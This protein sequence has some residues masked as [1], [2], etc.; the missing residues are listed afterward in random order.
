MINNIRIE[1]I[2]AE[3]FQLQ[4]EK[5]NYEDCCKVFKHEMTEEGKV[6]DAMYQEFT[7]KCTD[8]Y[9]EMYDQRLFDLIEDNQEFLDKAQE[10]RA[11]LFKTVDKEAR[12]HLVQCEEKEAE[13]RREL[14]LLVVV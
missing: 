9:N 7:Y 10:M 5:E 11:K 13:L 12:N 3:L 4:L 2:Y 1:Q 14:N 8:I 6:I